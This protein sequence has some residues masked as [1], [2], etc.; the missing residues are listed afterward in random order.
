MSSQVPL[1]IFGQRT[2]RLSRIWLWGIPGL[3]LTVL[4]ALADVP[5]MAKPRQPIRIVETPTECLIANRRSGT[6]SRMPWGSGTIAT[7]V[8]VADLLSDLAYFPKHEIVVAADEQTSEL[9]VLRWLDGQLNPVA[10]HPVEVAPVSLLSTSDATSFTVASLWSHRLSKW[11]IEGDRASATVRQA[12][13]LDLPFAPRCQCLCPDGRHIVVADAYGPELAVVQLEPL[14]LRSVWRIPGHNLRGL[15]V[16]A[17]GKELMIAHQMLN[18]F[19]PTTRDHVFWGNVVSNLLRTIPFDRLLA[20]ESASPSSPTKIYGRLY[21]LGQSGAAAGDPEQLVVTS[22]GDT[23]VALAGTG[24]VAFRVRGQQRFRRLA[25]GQRPTG[26]CV[27]PGGEVAWIANRFDDTVT[28]VD[29]IDFRV[30]RQIPL[31]PAEKLESVDRGERLF[32]D[33]TLSLDGWFSCH[34]CHTDGHTCGLLNDNFGDD[35]WGAPKRIPSL[36]GTAATAPWAWNGRQ[37][38]LTDQ[39]QKSLRLTMHGADQRMSDPTVVAAITDYLESLRPPP[40]VT[41]ARG[42]IDVAAAQ[43]GQQLFDRLACTQCHTPPTYSSPGTHDVGLRDERGG[44]DFNP[45]SL[46]GLGHRTGGLLHD[47]RCRSIVEVLAVHPEG[48]RLTDVERTDLVAFLES[49]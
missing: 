33:A 28:V 14:R 27:S 30:V 35:S 9:V 37:L 42:T 43:R 15:A 17:D 19:I 8:A 1:I 24:E 47:N 48:L 20:A 39:V 10:R 7:E 13:V 26:L 32:Y 12:G 21:P 18:D 41:T 25:V 2:R 22:R 45:P 3:V 23:L 11:T 46:S 31:G 38:R 34:S 5:Q 36:L 49:L 40:S 6:I 44:A 29:L 16:S 4:P